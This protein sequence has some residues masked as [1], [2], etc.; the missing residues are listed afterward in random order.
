MTNLISRRLEHR[1]DRYAVDLTGKPEA[2]ASSLQRLAAQSLAEE[3]PSR[4]TA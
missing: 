4:V 2:L 1:A 3:R